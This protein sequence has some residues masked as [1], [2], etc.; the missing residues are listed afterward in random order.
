MTKKAEVTSTDNG[1]TVPR[2]PFFDGFAPYSVLD[3]LDA[4][5]RIACVVD[6]FNHLNL[7]N[8][9]DE[10]LSSRAA[11]GYTWLSE[12]VRETL[13]YTSRRLSALNGKRHEEAQEKARYI[14]ALLGSLSVL[15]NSERDIVLNAMAAQL[16]ITRSDVDAFINST[17][18][19]QA[20]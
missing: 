11:D 10:G 3:C 20:V 18:A 13:V 1:G 15:K 16:E 14:S 7:G 17:S 2:H 8:D 4:I 9:I 6:M 12:S 5:N 19:G